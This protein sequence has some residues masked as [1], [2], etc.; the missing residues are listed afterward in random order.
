MAID[1]ESVAVNQDKMRPR[2]NHIIVTQILFPLAFANQLL[3]KR[4]VLA[5]N[6]AP[7]VGGVVEADV[8]KFEALLAEFLNKRVLFRN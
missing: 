3:A 2:R 1:D 5:D 4:M 7:N 6:L 8:H